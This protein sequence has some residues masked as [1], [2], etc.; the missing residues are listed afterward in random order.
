MNMAIFL[1]AHFI[2]QL[3]MNKLFVKMSH[4]IIMKTF[5]LS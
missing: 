2:Q 4:E 5:F 3:F 1:K